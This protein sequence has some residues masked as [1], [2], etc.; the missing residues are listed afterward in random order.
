MTEIE[1]CPYCRNQWKESEWYLGTC[2]HCG[3]KR[4]LKQTPKRTKPTWYLQSN[5]SASTTD[6]ISQEPS[7]SYSMEASM[8]ASP[9]EEPE[10]EED[11]IYN[12][13]LL[14]AA[15]KLAPPDK[16]KDKNFLKRLTRR[17]R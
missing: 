9:S 17:K 5:E 4:E 15:Q 14:S 3:G 13:Y 16:L 1:V 2:S 12:H 6:S 8:S 11:R 7:M 10:N